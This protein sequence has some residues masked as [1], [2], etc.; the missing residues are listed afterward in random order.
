VVCRT[1]TINPKVL[2]NKVTH[3][4]TRDKSSNTE[5]T[6]EGVN[7]VF[8]LF[9]KIREVKVSENIEI[10]ERVD[11][12]EDEL[13]DILEIYKN[14]VVDKNDDDWVNIGFKEFGSDNITQSFI[15]LPQ[16]FKNHAY[17][18]SEK[19]LEALLDKRDDLTSFLLSREKDNV[20]EMQPE[21]DGSFMKSEAV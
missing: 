14:E 11:L 18:N 1:L 17:H 7:P 21:L 10:I 20:V 3:V 12:S 4:V 16:L 19:V 6:N 13:I 15:K 5:K 8:S 2:A 9:N